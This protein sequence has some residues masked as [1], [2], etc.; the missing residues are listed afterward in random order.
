GLRAVR[1]EDI[2]HRTDGHQ[3]RNSTTRPAMTARRIAPDELRCSFANSCRSGALSGRS[4]H[5]GDCARSDRVTGFAQPL[6][7]RTVAT[8][9]TIAIQRA[10]SRN[11]GT[12]FTSYAPALS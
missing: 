10:T 9:S 12:P 7:Y 6:E 3:D 11:S 4:S 1:D 8:S 5:A 2:V